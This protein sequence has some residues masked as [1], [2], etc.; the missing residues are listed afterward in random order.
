MLTRKYIVRGWLIG[1]M[2]PLRSVHIQRLQ[3]SAYHITRAADENIKSH[4]QVFS[5]CS[6]SMRV[7]NVVLKI[8]LM[9]VCFRAVQALLVLDLSCW[10]AGTGLL[11][12]CQ[13]FLS[14]KGLRTVAT[15]DHLLFIMCFKMAV[16]SSLCR[17]GKLTTLGGAG[18]LLVFVC[19]L[20]TS[21]QLI[22]PK[23]F[24]TL[25]AGKGGHI[26]VFS[27]DVTFDGIS[28]TFQ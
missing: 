9:I 25:F 17:E 8:F 13:V 12:R 22:V 5:T 4:L 6:G 16:E 24:T 3:K 14:I 10:I 20:V 26:H 28:P 15:L 23:C 2:F 7:V 21:Q 27:S 19:F 11:M 1:Q 18:E